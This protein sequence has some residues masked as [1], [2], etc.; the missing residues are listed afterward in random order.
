M[1]T[2]HLIMKFVGVTPRG[3]ERLHE[4]IRGLEPPFNEKRRFFLL[5]QRP[6]AEPFESTLD[7]PVEI[8]K[9]E[10]VTEHHSYTVTV[11]IKVFIEWGGDPILLV[12]GRKK[13]LQPAMVVLRLCE[14]LGIFPEEE[15]A[16]DEELMGMK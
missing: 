1:S 6:E 7:N 16:V 2:P 3:I 13:R 15:S 9:S 8:L 10:W 11:K 4:A 12:E 14:A 5:R